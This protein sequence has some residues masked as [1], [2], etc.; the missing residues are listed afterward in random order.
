LDFFIVVTSI[1]ALPS[2][3]VLGL[4]TDSS[5]PVAS[6]R[7]LRTFRALRP[8]RM[9]NRAPGLKVVVDAIFKCLPAFINIGLVSWLVYLV[10]AI[11]GVQ[12]WAGKFWSC[13]DTSVESVKQ[14]TGLMADGTARVWAN[15]PLNF[16]NV[17][18]A[19]LTLFEVASLEIWLDVMYAAMDVPEKLGEQPQRDQ[20]WYFAAYFVLFIIV[21]SFLMMNLFVGAVVDNFNRIKSSMDREGA[22]MTDEQE[23]FVN[24]MKTMFTKKPTAKAQAPDPLQGTVSLVRYKVFQL[25]SLEY[26]DLLGPPPKLRSCKREPEAIFDQ[27]I[28]V[29]IAGNILVMAMP[30]WV[31]PASFTEVGSTA[32]IDAQATAYNT[33]LETCNVVFNFLFLVELLLKLLGLG[34]KQ[35]FET[36]MNTFDC[37]I[38]VVSLIGFIIDRS[39]SGLDPGLVGAIS[40]IKAGRVV[41]IFRL[42]MRVKGIRQLLETLIYTLPSLFNVC[43]LLLIVVFI[44]TVLGMAFFGNQE[45]SQPPFELYEAHAHFNRFHIG[46][47]TLFRMSTGESWNGIMHDSMENVSPYAWVY[48]FTYM[49]VG[50]NLLFQLIVAVV[51]EQ[52]S[53]ATDEEE[54][55]VKPDHIE[56]FSL[57]WREMDPQNTSRLTI[58]QIS[59]LV[60]S[61]DPPL[62]IMQPGIDRSPTEVSDFITESELAQ[63]GD[64]AHYVATFFK[65]VNYAYKKKFKSRWKGTLDQSILD[66]LTAQLNDN[67]MGGIVS[68]GTSPLGVPNDSALEREHLPP[69]SP[70]EIVNPF[71]SSSERGGKLPPLKTVPSSVDSVMSFG[72]N[73]EVSHLEVESADRH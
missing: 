53:A 71:H 31:Q 19:Q 24:H 1:F 6:L 10:F 44:F 5:G 39:L 61:L 22:V 4:S 48:Y 59:I 54:A 33:N 15:K 52:F 57:T 64:D 9:I 30:V 51:L 40:V 34:V 66:S 58:E 65:L 43:C 14:C 2:N 41:R 55:L 62:G 50:S 37:C 72:S 42:A 21:G 7:V 67:E 12:L 68:L 27:V 32:A 18:N 13:N 28:M 16:D 38:V 60:Q 56:M 17:L 46:F 23:A 49:I 8:L 73:A 11:M 29:L 36:K 3:P 69:Q 25:I 70:I 35:Y 26:N 63:E 47:F 20:S 45:F